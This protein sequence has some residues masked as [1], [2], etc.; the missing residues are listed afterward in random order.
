MNHRLPDEYIALV[1]AQSPINAVVG[2]YVKLHNAGDELK[3]ICPFH[4]EKSP[5]FTVSGSIWDCSNCDEGG[6]VVAFVQK[7]EH[8]SF[9]DA[10]EWLAA[11]YGRESKRVYGWI[12]VPDES[13]DKRKQE[14]M[15]HRAAERHSFSIVAIFYDDDPADPYRALKDLVRALMDNK[16]LV[17]HVMVP[18]GRDY[19]WFDI[20]TRDMVNFGHGIGLVTGAKLLVANEML[21]DK[22]Q[23]RLY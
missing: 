4:D 12:P 23:G 20:P 13:E 3:G 8:L 6:D 9:A 22:D 14:D 15:L 2:E 17:S 16:Q 10:V 21:W 7:I 19:D 18:Y 1:R 11:K 5:S